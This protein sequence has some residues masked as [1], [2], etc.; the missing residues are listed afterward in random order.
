MW[1]FWFFIIIGL[2]ILIDWGTYKLF[3][4][5]KNRDGEILVNKNFTIYAGL[6]HLSFHFEPGYY[7]GDHMM[8]IASTMFHRFFFNIPWWKVPEHEGDDYGFGFYLYNDDPKKLFITINLY[9][10][11]WNKT[12]WMPWNYEL[13][14]SI[15][16]GRDDKRYIEFYGEARERNKR[17]ARYNCKPLPVKDMYDIYRNL[18]FYWQAPYEYTLKNGQKQRCIGMYYVEEREWRPRITK[19]LPIFKL[20]RRVLEI[21][22][23][24]E[25][26]EKV[27]SWKGGVMGFSREILPGEDPQEAYQRIMKETKFN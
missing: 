27:G 22:F 11:S 8:L 3:P 20:S 1:V 18:D 5:N 9:W 21:N 14:H 4:G 19:F 13:H 17:A 2:F 16:E 10:G 24:A 12:L 6:H 7:D 25:M 23:T 26:G 15:I